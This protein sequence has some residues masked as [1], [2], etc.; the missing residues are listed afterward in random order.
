MNMNKKY[1]EKG[2][3]KKPKASGRQSKRQ[4]KYKTFHLF[5]MRFILWLALHRFFD[6]KLSVSTIHVVHNGTCVF[7]LV[8]S[9][10]GIGFPFPSPLLFSLVDYRGYVLTTIAPMSATK[11]TH[12]HINS[13]MRWPNQSPCRIKLNIIFHFF[14]P[15]KN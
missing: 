10:T 3:I 11:S 15:K 5:A 1:R 6:K 4:R 7:A 8:F 13:E 14:F 9:V 2:H 12:L